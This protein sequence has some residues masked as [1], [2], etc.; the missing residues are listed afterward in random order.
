MK[1][2]LSVVFFLFSMGLFAQ[3]RKEVENGIFVTFP[4]KPEYTT[5]EG[6]RSYIS[7]TENVIFMVQIVDLP[8]RAEYMIAERKFSEADKKT[9]ADSFLNNFVKGAMA[10]IGNK[11]QV[12]EIKKGKFYGRKMEYRA[13]NPATGDVSGRAKLALFIRGRIIAFECVLMNDSPRAVAEKDSFINSVN[14]K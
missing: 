8:Q 13:V 11:V 1:N 3:V 6:Y 12:Q 4:N 5:V 10:S 7:K 9:I 2:K 14:V